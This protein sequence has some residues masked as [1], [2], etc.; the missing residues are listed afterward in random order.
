MPSKK[1]K[2]A[3][4]KARPSF[5]KRQ[6][7]YELIGRGVAGTL[8]SSLL[9]TLI[10]AIYAYNSAEAVVPGKSVLQ[11]LP[12]FVGIA[13]AVVAPPVKD[14]LRTSFSANKHAALISALL[15]ALVF[16]LILLLA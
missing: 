8:V 3:P 6:D 4:V 16:G 11:F 5:R 7:N 14:F 9:V 15:P 10:F 13:A 12:P 2:N 1:K